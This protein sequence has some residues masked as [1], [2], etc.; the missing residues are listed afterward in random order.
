MNG[1]GAMRVRRPLALR[2][3]TVRLTQEQLAEAMEVDRTTV[4]RWERGGVPSPRF[5]R[6]LADALGLS[7]FE[8]AELL[9]GVAVTT[10]VTR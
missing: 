4:A 1:S 3:A 5:R 9:E 10:G 7:V 6:R 2:P 8:L